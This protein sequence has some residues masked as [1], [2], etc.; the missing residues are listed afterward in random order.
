MAADR[1]RL[2]SEEE[3]VLIRDAVDVDIS[4]GAVSLSTYSYPTNAD[5]GPKIPFSR[6]NLEE[7]HFGGGNGDVVDRR[8]R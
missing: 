5:G 1:S 7:F 3:D 8:N 2:S 4:N 6:G